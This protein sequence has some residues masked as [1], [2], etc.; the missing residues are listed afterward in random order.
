MDQK[1]KQE[2]KVML[3]ENRIVLALN[4]HILVPIGLYCGYRKTMFQH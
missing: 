3:P 4:S 1:A 2:K